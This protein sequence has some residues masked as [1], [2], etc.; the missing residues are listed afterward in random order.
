[1]TFLCHESPGQAKALFS[2]PPFFPK[3]RNNDQR[4]FDR[5]SVY[6]DDGS[7]VAETNKKSL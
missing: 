2:L 3:G 5:L 6:C 7:R 4:S 1:M